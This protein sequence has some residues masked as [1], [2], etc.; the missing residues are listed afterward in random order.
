M[1]NEL[2]KLKSDGENSD[3]EK[4]VNSAN[5]HLSNKNR[6]YLRK[7]FLKTLKRVLIITSEVYKLIEEPQ[8]EEMSKTEDIKIPVFDGRDYNIWK[9]R[10]LL[11][12]KWKKCDEAATREK[13]QT[14]EQAQWDEMNLKAMNYIYGSIN[15]DQLEFVGEKE[16]AFGIMEK[17]DQLYLKESTALQICIRNKLDKMKLKNYEDS[18]T[19]FTDFEKTINE[20]K[21]AGGK[22]NEEEK[23]NYMLRT[24]PDS[25]SYV[26]DLIDAMKTEDRN[27]EFLKRKIT[28]WDEKEKSESNKRKTSVF[29]TESERDVTCYGCGKPGHI[30]KNCRNPWKKKTVEADRMEQKRTGK[31]VREIS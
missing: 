7:S 5:F 27:C 22:V 21:G 23:L 26:G 10:L 24:L 6:N 2:N 29:K 18:S 12:L 19:F 1:G 3:L 11:Y 17:F 13:L 14:D 31:E 16:T 25:L 8:V 28:M 9:K 20:L 30:I 4:E 15:N